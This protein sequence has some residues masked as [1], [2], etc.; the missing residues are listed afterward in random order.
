M[1]AF[2]AAIL[3]LTACEAKAVVALHHTE[4]GRLKI[5]AIAAQIRA[6]NRL[7]SEVNGA[8]QNLARAKTAKASKAEL[9]RLELQ[10]ER[11]KDKQRAAYTRAIHMT[12]D[13]YDLHPRIR[14]GTS[15][16]PQTRGRVIEWLP[17]AHDRAAREVRAAD[18]STTRVPQPRMDL[19]GAAYPDGVVFIDPSTFNHPAGVGYLAST[20]LHERTHFEQYITAGRGDVM[21]VA[22]AQREAYDAERI[23]SG[24][25]LD[26][27]IPAQKAAID[28]V[29]TLWA[30]EDAKVKAREQR[31]RT[32]VGRLRN[33]YEPETLSTAFDARP[34]TNEELAAIK[35]DAERLR[36]EI[37]AENAERTT[38]INHAQLGYMT[39]LTAPRAADEAP[40]MGYMKPLPAPS[41]A[42]EPLLASVEV[43]HLARRACVDD[44]N[45]AS[46]SLSDFYRLTEEDLRRLESSASGGDCISMLLRRLVTMRRGGETLDL[47]RLQRETQNIRNPQPIHE[48]PVERDRRSGGCI[49]RGV[50]FPQC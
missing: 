10:L 35:Q 6:A 22:K 4:D 1:K 41:R 15:V 37:A 20:L 8:E 34:R 33:W 45:G 30:E 23:H 39:P 27:S 14:T 2:L 9:H 38:R 47:A 21:T 48:V 32:L 46:Y 50:W 12:L 28:E 40:Q 31:D 19:A 17:I 5:Q 13:A 43:Y 11:E 36:A 16:M 3:V 44:W 7:D 26:A 24:Y 49:K 18:G 42:S 25:F 29:E